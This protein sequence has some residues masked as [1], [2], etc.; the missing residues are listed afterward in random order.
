VA[1]LDLISLYN[2]L[3]VEEKIEQ[4][5][6]E[7]IEAEE[8]LRRSDRKQQLIERLISDKILKET[9]RGREDII[10]LLL[11]LFYNNNTFNINYASITLLSN[12]LYTE[13]TV[14]ESFRQL[15]FITEQA[16]QQTF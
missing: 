5:L 3:F 14:I 1:V 8:E 16:E 6:S 13:N 9:I 4:F 15:I 10:R 12:E 7:V 11:L 2:K